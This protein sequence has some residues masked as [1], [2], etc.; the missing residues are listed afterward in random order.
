MNIF[1]DL[2]GTILNVSERYYF[3]HSLCVDSTGKSPLARKR[4]LELRRE[5]W[6]EKRIV[7]QEGCDPDAHMECWNRAIES[8]E[9]LQR[10]F[11][12]EGILHC[13][14]KL[15]TDHTLFLVTLRRKPE[16]LEGQLEKYD[17]KKYFSKI[18]TGSP[19]GDPS[20]FK[21]GLIKSSGVACDIIVGDTEVDVH[22]AKILNARSLT[23]T[24]GLRGK[25][26]LEEIGAQFFASSPSEILIKL[27]NYI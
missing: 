22:A 7:N 10:D 17:L 26:F 12:V 14:E 24:Y 13:L 6:D 9:A 20:E 1:F 21:V 23:I 2:D 3:V 25:K 19:T 16:N 11:L 27:R 5:G 18:T 4:Y 8:Q 15:S